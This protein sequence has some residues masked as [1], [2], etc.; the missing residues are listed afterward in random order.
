MLAQLTDAASAATA[1]FHHREES[2]HFQEQEVDEEV[3]KHCPY[4]HQIDFYRAARDEFYASQGLVDF[5]EFEVRKEII[6]RKKAVAIEEMIYRETTGMLWTGMNRMGE[7]LWEYARLYSKLLASDNWTTEYHRLKGTNPM[8]FAMQAYT[9]W[10]QVSELWAKAQYTAAGRAFADGLFPMKQAGESN[11]T[12]D[13]LPYDEPEQGE[14]VSGYVAGSIMAF[15]GE[16]NTDD[17]ASCLA[18]QD[19]L[20]K[21]FQESSASIMKRYNDD[22]TDG[23]AH[24]T[25][26][27]NSIEGAVSEC[28]A[29]TQKQVKAMTAKLGK[30]NEKTIIG[31]LADKKNHVELMMVNMKYNEVSH[32]FQEYAAHLGELY[33]TLTGF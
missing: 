8:A 28:K 23:V 18:D 32:D 1:L 26:V 24:M 13:D 12:W 30:V 3:L 11:V 22:I 27:L 19:V 9:T 6:D 4:H 21:G 17:L 29:S 15:T 5:Q 20:L 10:N 2:H 7:C 33:M 31:N 16:Q 25:Q 14:E